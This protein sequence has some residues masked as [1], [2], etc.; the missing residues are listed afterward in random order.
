MNSFFSNESSECFQCGLPKYFEVTTG[1]KRGLSPSF[2]FPPP[3]PEGDGV[4]GK[5][6]RIG[7]K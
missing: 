2:Q 5:N 1:V 3:S 6:W 7:L 4:T